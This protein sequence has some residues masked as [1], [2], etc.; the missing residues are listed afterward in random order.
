[1]LDRS[2]AG[3]SIFVAL[4]GEPGIGKTSLLDQLERQ[5][6]ERGCVT[7]VGRAAE[8]QGDIP[9]GLFMDAFDPYLASL[10]PRV[11]DRMAVDRLGALASV[12]PSL[13]MLGEAVEHPVSAVERFRVHAAVRELL[14]RLA[15]RRPVLLVLDDLHWTDEATL[16]TLSYLARH[17]PQ[18]ELMIAAAYRRGHGTPSVSAAIQSIERK[19]G[20]AV[21]D[22]EPLTEASLSMIVSDI[23]GADLTRL[24]TLSGGNP[25]FALE[26]MRA[27][28]GSLAEIGDR[29]DAPP[30]VVRAIDAELAAMEAGDRTFVHTLAVLGDPFDVELACEVSGETEEEV[31][32]RIDELVRRDLIRPAG[33]PRRFQFR[34]PIVRSAVYGSCRPSVRVACHRRAAQALERRAAPA[35]VVATH[36]EQSAPIGDHH[37]VELLAQAGASAAE[38][39]P[40]SAAR[41]FAA[42]LRLLPGGADVI[43]RVALLRRLA[44]AQSATGELALARDSLAT[45]LELLPEHHG[46]RVEIL[47]AWASLE[48]L[49]G[50]H[51][52]ANDRLEATL[53]TTSPDDHASRVGLLVALVTNSFYAADNEAMD[54]W[55][56]LA[57]ADATEAGDEMLLAAALAAAAKGAAFAG[58]V[59][60]AMTHQA[61]AV[62]LLDAQSD[63]VLASHLGALVDVVI[64]EL[65]L[66]LYASCRAHA[67]RAL[68]LARR[69]GQGQLVPAV[70][71]ALGTSLWVL[72]EL[73][74]SARVL[75]EAIEAARLASDEQAVAWNLFN[76]SLQAVM[77]GDID[78]AVVL[79]EESVEMSESFEPGLISA[80][81]GVVLAAALI[82]DGQAARAVEMLTGRAGGE[83]VAMIGGGWRAVFLE[84]LARCLLDLGELDR[85]RIAAGRARAQAEAT[86]LRLPFIAA[87]RSEA[88]VALSDD[89]AAE[90]VE[91]ALSAV[92]RS[93]ALGA[94]IHVATSLFLAGRA[95]LAAGRIDDAVDRFDRSAAE[96]D[97]LGAARYR[98]QVDSE[99]R[100]LGRSIHRRS[101]P[102]N[103][104]G[105]GI[106]TLTGRE[107]E[108]ARLIVDRMTNRQIAEQLFLST[109]TVE[110]HI[111]NIFNKLGATSRVDVAR[112]VLADDGGGLAH[113]V[114]TP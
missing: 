19:L 104:G 76:R 38:S 33:L 72:G 80:Y 71:P 13:R 90:A 113:P 56:E 68:E 32:E 111:R 50:G 27:K 28:P 107:L 58:R 87:D 7:L 1:M 47:I 46:D 94:R 85:A 108:V 91:L 99:L 10:E 79:A 75:D 43:E 86:G 9:F 34:H 54:R 61:R 21:I 100:R 110:S 84:L 4:A 5:A 73:E 59:E 44:A 26:L 98:N 49:L 109:K 42:A 105:K 17:P 106:E 92:E 37:A 67:E 114:S 30:G 57:V 45:C 12:F 24:F 52:Q 15:A 55:A 65:Y 16:E 69:N 18:A 81:A 96:F 63:D 95:L 101:A 22:V 78:T 41:W 51:G 83:E 25:F 97:A 103:L 82:E 53:A 60:R 3:S 39:A 6:V 62:A 36:V 11:L 2:I 102:G 88:A 112:L 31:F 48:Q 29:D 93:E 66:D 8:Y 70:V 23:D 64:A 89:R 77:A 40:A 35:G 14:E 74:A 20:S